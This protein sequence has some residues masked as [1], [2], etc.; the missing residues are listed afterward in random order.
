MKTVQVKVNYPFSIGPVGL[1]LLWYHLSEDS[2]TFQIMY[3][4]PTP[5]KDAERAEWLK[6]WNLY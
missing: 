1:K 2:N 6:F 4:M 5:L 3:K